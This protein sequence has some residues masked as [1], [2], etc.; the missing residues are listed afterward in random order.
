MHHLRA[1][2]LFWI[3]GTAAA[4]CSASTIVPSAAQRSVSASVDLIAGETQA[5]DANSIFSGTLD[6]FNET[7]GAAAG[8]DPITGV[9]SASQLSDITP[10][11]IV[12]QADL[13]GELNVP[14]GASLS[15]SS[16]GGG[17][18]LSVTFSVSDLT[19]YTL[20]AHASASSAI[21]NSIQG[22]VLTGAGGALVSAEGYDNFVADVN[23]AGV[24]A[25]GEYTLL[26]YFTLSA[27]TPSV[28]GPFSAGALG[29]FDVNF[30]VPE[31][32]SLTVVLLALL[33][34][35]RR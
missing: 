19:A 9:V 12:G 17:A 14:A 35:R 34:C 3:S 20:T 10:L 2:S 28:A 15:A 16:L 11:S 18:G 31:P 6:P 25:P 4:L 24:L 1:A 21:P 30:Q 26:V 5:N 8:I 13:S 32:S 22:V 29:H 23:T 27:D 7:V 33:A